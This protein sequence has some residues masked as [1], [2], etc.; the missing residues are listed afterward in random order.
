MS[1]SQ[2]QS[3]CPNNFIIARKGEILM[4]LRKSLAFLVTAAAFMIATAVASEQNTTLKEMGQKLNIDKTNISVS[5]ISSGG[6]MAHQFH[7]A[8]SADL[9]GAGIIAGGP[10]YCA[11]GNVIKGMT[12]CTAFISEEG[13]KIFMAGYRELCERWYYRGP[14]IAPPGKKASEA[15]IE[16]AKKS[17]DA[18]ENESKNN[19]IDDL[20]GLLSDRVILIHGIR[21]TLLPRGVM[22][23]L[24]QYYQGIYAKEQSP[25]A[26]EKKL[27]Y[28]KTLPIAHAV[29]TDNLI[30]L[31]VGSNVGACQAFGSPYLNVCTKQD[32]V[33]SCCPERAKP[34]CKDPVNQVG[35]ACTQ[36]DLECSTQCVTSIDAAEA[37]LKHIYGSLNPRCGDNYGSS[38]PSCADIKVKN[39]GKYSVPPTVEQD[40]RK[41]E[42][43]D[44]RCQWLKKHLFAFDQTEVAKDLNNH[45]L[46]RKGF[47]F[48]P[49][50]CAEGRKCKLHIAFHGCLQGYGLQGHLI[51]QAIYS[52]DWTHFVEN[53]GYNEWAN[54][55]D[56]VVLYPQVGTGIL[57]GDIQHVNPQGCWDFWGYTDPKYHT[58]GGQQISAVWKM[59]E[60]LVPS[61]KQ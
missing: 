59:V 48:V 33:S 32:C 27:V 10:Y 9:V 2:E 44:P 31:Q 35:S 25:K 45:Y 22:D 61:L 7:V 39:W 15:A 20:Q 55:N 23:A 60:A 43:I 41:G 51:E 47:L 26:D 11:E 40:C 34:N 14:G 29:P 49:Q 53:A 50:N 36:C 58:K 42:R 24:D 13:C 3:T 18:T 8:H 16:M 56:I 28:L 1:E 21:D 12:E 30:D 46:S 52:M 54:T 5:G 4:T 19:N 6:F 57:T 38:I 37:I 17:I